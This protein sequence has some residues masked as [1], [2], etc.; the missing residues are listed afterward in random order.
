MQNR[1]N[2]YCIGKNDVVFEPVVSGPSYVRIKG[3]KIVN[4]HVSRKCDLAEFLNTPL[5]HMYNMVYMYFI[6]DLLT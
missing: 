5:L 3:N 1:G 4:L 6:Q 2:F